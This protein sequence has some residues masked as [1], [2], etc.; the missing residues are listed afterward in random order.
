MTDLSRI[1]R[2]ALVE[3]LL[4]LLKSTFGRGESIL[5]SGFGRFQIRQK[6]ARRGRNPFTGGDILLRPRTVLAFKAS[7]LLRDKIA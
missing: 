4:E 2:R 7:R 5:I 3:S 1:Q 6:E